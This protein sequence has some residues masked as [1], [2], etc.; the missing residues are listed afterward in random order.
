M[1]FK[2]FIKILKETGLT[3]MLLSFII[4]Y[5]VASLIMYFA[6]PSIKTIAD[7]LWYTFVAATSIGFG[8]FYPVTHIGRIITVIIT[9]YEIVVAAMIPGVVVAY[10][11]EK[12]KI[13][14]NQTISTFLEKLEQLPELTKEELTELAEKVKR[15][16]K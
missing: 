5:F 7:A 15:F 4:V 1:H 11:S 10:Y 9:I 6:E 13:K 12:L 8:D 14:E 3:S 2:R 16:N